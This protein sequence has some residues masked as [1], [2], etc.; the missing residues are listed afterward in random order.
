MIGKKT[1]SGRTARKFTSRNFLTEGS[2]QSAYFSG[3][4]EPDT[5]TL[6]RLLKK[7]FNTFVLEC[8][9]KAAGNMKAYEVF[10]K[11]RCDRLQINQKYSSG[12]NLTITSAKHVAE[13]FLKYT[14]AVIDAEQR[15]GGELRYALQQKDSA[16]SICINGSISFISKDGSMK[17]DAPYQVEIDFTLA[18]PS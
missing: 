11:N 2:R 18:A 9:F 10:Q 8:E 15:W 13:L 14:V 3:L 4:R 1:E 7:H 16:A 5:N 17:Y 12:Q 6:A